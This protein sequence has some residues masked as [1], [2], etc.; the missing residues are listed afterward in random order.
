LFSYQANPCSYDPLEGLER[1]LALF[2]GRV[3]YEK[4]IE[5]F[6]KL[7]M[8]G[9]KIVCGVGPLELSLKKQY[10]D[11]TW[12][13]LLAREELA[14]V[15]ASADVFVFPSKSETFGLVL[16][17]AMACGTPVAAFPVDGPFE[18]LCN[19]QGAPEGGILDND[20]LS[21][22]NQ[23]LILPR[24]EARQRA[25]KFSWENAAK[26]FENNL[27]PVAVGLLAIQN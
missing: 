27:V 3:S 19:S 1:P 9:T 11:V 20:L 22:T 5:S 10:P 23:A 18:V 26:M 6:L 4:N 2:V 13:G 17:E 15:Y 21:A 14:K 8:S 7:K 24:S 16:L 25:L 12:L